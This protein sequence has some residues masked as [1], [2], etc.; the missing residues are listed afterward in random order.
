M[1][2]IAWLPSTAGLKE[3]LRCA[4]SP[5]QLVP[6]YMIRRHTYSVPSKLFST[7][8]NRKAGIGAPEIN[9]EN[10]EQEKA[11]GNSNGNGR[12]Q[13]NNDGEGEERKVFY[14][15]LVPN[16]PSYFTAQP[17][18]VDDLLMLQTLLRR[19]RSLPLAKP[20]S[21]P[22]VAWTSPME[23]K[24]SVGES[25][26]ASKYRKIIDVLQRLYQIHPTLMPKEV[27]EAIDDYKRG[28]NN[29]SNVSTLYPV[30]NTGRALGV[31][32][33]KASSARAWLVEGTGEVI[34][35][36]KT[37]AEAFG[38]VHD[39]ESAVW[40]LKSTARMDKYNVWALVTGGGTTGQAEALT[41]AVGK[42]LLAHEP[43]LKPVLRRG[44]LLEIFL[45]KLTFSLF[46]L[47]LDL[48]ANAI[49]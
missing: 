41:L 31:G 48:L 3:G 30:D 23:Y 20:G 38:R 16:S 10:F 42:A 39:R 28:V 6:S 47:C 13:G 49:L 44:K 29:F 34:I 27:K 32:R 43:A 2:M 45:L 25:V 8:S 36:G 17:L 9:F 46:M 21:L 24:N 14:A 40:A 33:R 19:Y 22:R 11:K 5:R 26:K 4:Y 7:S 37:L 15:R 1:K 18:F 12:G 35:N